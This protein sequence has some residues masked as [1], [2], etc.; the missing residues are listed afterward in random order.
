MVDR[1]QLFDLSTDPDEIHNLASAPEQSERVK[2]M[3]VAMAKEQAHFGDTAPLTVPN[4]LPA[5][6]HPKAAKR[7]SPSSK[8][9]P[10]E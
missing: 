10:T 8:E 3:L 9:T 5:E 7:N 6:W 2:A 4:P 1:T